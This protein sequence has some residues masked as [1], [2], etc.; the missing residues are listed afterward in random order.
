MDEG[1]KK[2]GKSSSERQAAKKPAYKPTL[3]YRSV[4]GSK[5][6]SSSRDL[7]V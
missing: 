5:W 4:G 6:G 3:A 7:R 1:E 2:E